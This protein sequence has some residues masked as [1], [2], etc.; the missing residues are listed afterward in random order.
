MAAP[1]PVTPQPDPTAADTETLVDLGL[2]P[3]QP[4]PEPPPQE[5]AS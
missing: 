1:Q 3:P 4:T 5:S 2:L